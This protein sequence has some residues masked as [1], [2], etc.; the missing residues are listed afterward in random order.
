M[1]EEQTPDGKKRSGRDRRRLFD[2]YRLDDQGAYRL[3][4]QGK[5]KRSGTER[6]AQEEKRVGWHRVSKW[7]SAPD[8]IR[9][10]E[11]KTISVS[12][13][14]DPRE[15]YEFVSDPANLPE[16]AAGLGSSIEEINEEGNASTRQGTAKI[17]FV[18][19]NN[20]GVLDHYVTPTPGAEVYVPMRV[21]P[22]A[23]GAE[24]L[25]TLFRL[26]G[27]TDE[28]FEQDKTL[29]LTDLMALK[30]LLERNK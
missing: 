9:L 30:H 12:I 29:V 6:R 14:R 3:A 25:F 2:V 17:R 16:W 23:D 7:G 22:N 26:P 21:V 5:E 15:V 28:K 19:R 4:D 18:D 11:S 27:V 10:L 8:S 13:G 24:L 1:N 20:F